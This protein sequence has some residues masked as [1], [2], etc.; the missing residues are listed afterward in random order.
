MT[1]ASSGTPRKEKPNGNPNPIIHL[2]DPAGTVRANLLEAG[3]A[4]L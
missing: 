2:I 1:Q 3:R 4:N